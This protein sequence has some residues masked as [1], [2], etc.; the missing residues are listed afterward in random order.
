MA[1]ASEASQQA[2]RSGMDPVRLVVI[3][4]LIASLVLAMFFGHIFTQL[5]PSGWSNPEVLA[6]LDWTLS[7]I[8]GFALGIGLGV[9]AWVHK[10]VRN[11]SLES[12]SE[13]MRVTWPTWGETRVA[14]VAVV[15]ASF[16]AAVLL[17][18]IDTLSYQVMVNWLPDLW[19]KL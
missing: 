19:G 8:V 10:G 5:W 2:N 14:T 7:T 13:L 18:G 1:T 15:I 4:Y 11:R 12:A 16:V 3:F 6:G 17:F 9:F